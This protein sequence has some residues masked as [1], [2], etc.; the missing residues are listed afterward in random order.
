MRRL[1]L[2]VLAEYAAP[3]VRDV[4]MGWH[5][6][7]EPRDPAVVFAALDRY[8]PELIASDL[9]DRALE[10]ASA[11]DHVPLPDEDLLELVEETGSGSGRRVAALAAL[12]A[13]RS[14]DVLERALR[15]ALE[16]DDPA[17]RARGRDVLA[18]L[19]P[20]EALA[21]LAALPA[22]ATLV[23]RQ[24]AW[25][26]LASIDREEARRRVLDALDRLAAG[27]LDPAVALEVMEAA[28]ALGGDAVRARLEVL[29][30]EQRADPM[31]ARRYALAGGDPERGRRVF[32]SRGDCQRCHGSSRH[33]AGAGPD[34]SGVAH[35]RD[36]GYLLE[37]VLDP[38]AEIAQGFAT[39][40]VVLE[41]GR[42]V[43]GNLAR[44]S[45]VE[46]VL[47]IGGREQ[48]IPVDQIRERSSAASAMPPMGLA[49]SP[50]ELRDLLAYVATL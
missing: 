10:I 42:V 15:V 44:E 17:L 16:S 12:D 7:L 35:R 5:R 4:A 43:S 9:G 11:Y 25:R 34:L 3:G 8:G 38:Q 30:A 50:R 31:S 48:S 21:A 26:T 27:D 29:E 6:P 32:E 41:D 18:G 39:Q 2:D 1:A 23:E 33:G 49:L 19:R 24:A 37:S 20:D 13:R 40:S 22:S 36:P 28:R 45:E 47:E 46:L 14:G